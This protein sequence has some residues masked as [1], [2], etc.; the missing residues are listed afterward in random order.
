MRACV[1]LFSLNM[2]VLVAGAHEPETKNPT[3]LAM[4]RLY[5][6]VSIT[7][8][9][10]DTQI[11]KD[12]HSNNTEVHTYYFDPESSTL[13]SCLGEKNSE[14]CTGPE[15]AAQV[16]WTEPELIYGKQNGLSP[17]DRHAHGSYFLSSPTPMKQWTSYVYYQGKNKAV[18]CRKTLTDYDFEYEKNGEHIFFHGDKKQ[19]YVVRCERIYPK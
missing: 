8:V 19:E 2:V 3:V 17:I 14:V 12:T 7:Y 10:V 5:H 13:Y 1:L 4:H 9:H 15:W 18:R 6:K 16:Q 11:F